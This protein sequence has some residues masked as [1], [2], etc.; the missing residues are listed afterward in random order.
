MP[1]N[2]ILRQLVLRNLGKKTGGK[3]IHEIQQDLKEVGLEI[4]DAENKTKINTL[5]K[6]YKFSAEMIHRR[7]MEI[8]DELRKLRSERM[9]KYWADRKKTTVQPSKR[10]RI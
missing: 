7:P 1:E 8:S 2:R 10:K 5:L 9:K 3:W 6:A 4:A